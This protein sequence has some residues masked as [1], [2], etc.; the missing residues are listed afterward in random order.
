MYHWNKIYT[1][2]TDT[3]TLAQA[4]DNTIQCAAIV[5]MKYKNNNINNLQKRIE[6]KVK[7]DEE[8]E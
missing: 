6:Y 1:L 2:N 5:Y 3:Y 8:D 7:E 4:K